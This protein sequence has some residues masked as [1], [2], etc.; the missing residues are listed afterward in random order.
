VSEETVK[1]FQLQPGDR[2][3]LRLLNLGDHRY[4]TIP[5]RFVG[6]VREFPTAPRDSFLVANASYI[7]SGTGSA[8]GEIVLLRASGDPTRVA[9]TARKTAQSLPGALVTD[10]RGVL[11]LI[12]SSLTAVDVAGL[13][14]LELGFAVLMAV[15]AA[16]VAFA[17]DLADRRR[18]FAIL[19]ALGAKPRQLGAFLWAEGLL[20]LLGGTV[21]GLPTGFLIAA[22]LVKLLTGVFDPPPESLSVPWPYL[23]AT[24]LAVLASVVATLLATQ[25]VA[26]RQV[27][28]R[29]RDM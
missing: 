8:A 6:V 2:I 28:E 19:A 26:Q 23:A 22:M 5:F 18:T 21:I 17:L 20:I 10:V 12:A 1:D 15:G 29:L 25:A 24:L 4:H 11:S 27:S 13:T 16:G 14:R 9:D 3:N 7:G